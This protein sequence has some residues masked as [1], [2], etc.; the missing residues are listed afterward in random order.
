MK[1]KS[2]LGDRYADNIL[3]LFVLVTATQRVAIA[4]DGPV[5][6]I[7]ND[8]EPSKLHRIAIPRLT[9]QVRLL[10]DVKPMRSPPVRLPA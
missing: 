10:E 9:L 2:L 4:A 1:E 5:I 3:N 8:P 7:A 6:G